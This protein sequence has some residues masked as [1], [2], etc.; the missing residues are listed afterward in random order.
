MNTNPVIVAEK[1]CKAYP[2]YRKPL[3]MVWEVL[4]RKVRHDTFWALRDVS[5]TVEEKKR[6]GIIGPNG[7]GKST[8]LK[9]ITGN[10]QPT[11]GNIRTNGKISALLSLASSLNPEES[12]LRNIHFNLIVNGCRPSDIPH[13]TEDIVDFTEL[14]AFIYS[15]VK[16]YSSGMNARL[17]FAISTAMD[18]E[19]L[20]VD[21]VLSVGD[22]YFMGKARKRMLE[23]VDRGRALVFVSHSTQEIRNLCNTVIWLENGSVRNKGP[24]D[25][26]CTQYEEDYT[27]K[28]NETERAG[29]IARKQRRLFNILPNEMFSADVYRVRIVPAGGNSAFSDT[30]YIRNIK[31]VLSGN[32]VQEVPLIIQDPTS[33]ETTVWLDILSSDWGRLYDRGNAECRV[34]TA[35]SGKSHGGHILLKRIADLEKSSILKLE[36]IFE[37]NSH[38]GREALGVEFLDYVSAEW[39]KAETL[40]REKCA[41]EWERIT[42]ACELPMVSES[43]F[44]RALQK[45]VEDEKPAIEII[46]VTLM[47]DDKEAH[48]VTER[49]P[50]EIRVCLHAN[51]LVPRADVLIHILRSDGVYV[52]WQSSGMETENLHQISGKVTVCFQFTNNAFNA[53]EYIVTAICANGWDPQNNFPHSTIFDTRMNGLKFAVI[54]EYNISCM[55]FGQ[56]NMR[57]PVTY[58]Y[59]Q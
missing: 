39:K 9:L 32:E 15:P 35:Q 2:I 34:L 3:D 54:K 30:H 13:L 49:Q 20:V 26:I 11:Q 1:L 44:Q 59:N 55:D 43:Q 18:P 12:G 47:A 8:L 23:L 22:A 51:R 7:A 50:F 46:R 58:L 28:R 4:T 57:V 10:L 31:L 6:L 41:A 38:T 33:P 45:A 17:A 42:T 37:E 16:T 5:F 27:K 56:I 24:A 40:R 14:G 19:I 21:E 48:T 52:F 25:Y 36:L 29:N 53:G